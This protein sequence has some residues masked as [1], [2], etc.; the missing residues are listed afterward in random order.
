[1]KRYILSALA[2]G[3]LTIAPAFAQSQT[4]A[5]APG[6]T[7]S[8]GEHHADRVENQQDRIRN[9]MKSGQL[10]NE[11]ARQLGRD[12]ANIKKHATRMKTNAGGN[13]SEAQEQKIHQAMNR[14]SRRIYR[15][16]H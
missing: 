13:L 15:A 12:E 11:Q 5:P 3:A 1:M 8:E 2:G 6:S 4:Q 10:N 7:A 16:K 14:Q 9:G